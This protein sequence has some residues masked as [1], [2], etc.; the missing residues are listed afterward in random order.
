[1]LSNCT[2]LAGLKAAFSTMCLF[3]S[4]AYFLFPC[5][6]Q[7]ASHL[8]HFMGESTHAVDIDTLKMCMNYLPD[9][10]VRVCVTCT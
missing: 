10:L 1:M 3:S 9:N 8:P 2:I 6:I 7:L 4:F 5:I